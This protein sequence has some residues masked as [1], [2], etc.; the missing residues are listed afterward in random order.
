MKTTRIN[1]QLMN[2]NAI[3]REIELSPDDSEIILDALRFYWINSEKFE[4]EFLERGCNRLRNQAF[5]LKK[6]LEDVMDKLK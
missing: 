4:K 2:G 1:V 3:L 6:D 5:Y